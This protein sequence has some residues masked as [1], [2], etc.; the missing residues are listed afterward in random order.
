MV[1]KLLQELVTTT[2]TAEGLVLGLAELDKNEME[3]RREELVQAVM[4]GAKLLA[5]SWSQ[6]DGPF[7]TQHQMDDHQMVE[8]EF[9]T[10]ASRVVYLPQSVEGVRFLERWYNHR[11]KS[12][13]D[14]QEHA[15]PGNLISLRPKDQPEHH[16]DITL[17]D[18]TATGLRLGLTL[19]LSLFEKFPLSMTVE[20]EEQDDD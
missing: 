9:Q 3:E 4:D 12:L 14:I 19:A 5:K 17:N 18:D 6:V 20:D 7:A 8:D 15:Q 16:R 10:L 1:N 2:K 11:L 13:K